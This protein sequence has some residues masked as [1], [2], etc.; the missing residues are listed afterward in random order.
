[1][2]S[3]LEFLLYN[4]VYFL[5]FVFV[6]QFVVVVGRTC[7]LHLWGKTDTDFLHFQN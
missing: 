5:G 4:F 7:L 2:I 6:V 3:V 1:L